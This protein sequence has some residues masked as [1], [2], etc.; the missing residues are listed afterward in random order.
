MCKKKRIK[1]CRMGCDTNTDTIQHNKLIAL[2]YKSRNEQNTK[3]P[4]P[5]TAVV[6]FLTTHRQ[7]WFEDRLASIWPWMQWLALSSVRVR[8]WG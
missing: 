5:Q 3:I 2:W 1:V 6:V 7:L 4:I 8:D